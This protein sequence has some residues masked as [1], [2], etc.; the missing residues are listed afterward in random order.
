MFDNIVDKIKETGIH[1]YGFISPSDAIFYDWVRDACE[2]NK[3]RK[4]DTTWVCPPAVS[5]VE[6][7]KERCLQYDTMMI[8]S[9]LFHLKRPFDYRGMLK[10]MSEFK[11]MATNLDELISPLVGDR[12]VFSNEGCDFCKK[13]TYP[14]SPC[15]FP[16]KIHHSLEGYGLIVYDLAKQAGIKYDNGDLTMTYFGGILFNRNSYL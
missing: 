8:F 1:E 3:C 7:C 9:G 5:T 2:D 13:C 16:D 14:Y 12:L 6:E 11:K 15:R 4:Y 10:G